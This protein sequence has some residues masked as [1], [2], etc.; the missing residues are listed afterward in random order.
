MPGT[1]KPRGGGAGILYLCSC[2]KPLGA[3]Y[4]ISRISLF[5]S[6]ARRRLVKQ[7]ERVRVRSPPPP[8]II[9]P[10]YPPTA[11][12]PTRSPTLPLPTLRKPTCVSPLRL[13]SPAA[14]TPLLL[15][16]IHHEAE[17]SPVA[18]QLPP[19]SVHQLRRP[20]SNFRVR[21]RLSVL[22]LQLRAS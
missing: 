7:P 1:A 22:R 13:V 9:S 10:T 15:F 18:H 5:V 16:R 2:G 6:S 19:A 17:N 8:T 11:S 21:T 14:C 12:C 4:S 3:S 20:H